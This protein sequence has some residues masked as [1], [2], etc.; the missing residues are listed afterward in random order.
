M[1][2][3]R[4]SLKQL[5][6]QK[7]EI[8]KDLLAFKRS[9]DTIRNRLSEAQQVTDVP[10]LLNWAGTSAVMGSLELSI[11]SLEKELSDYTKAI[12]LVQN[13]EI[14]NVDDD[15]PKP[16]VLKLVPRNHD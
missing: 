1:S 2:E 4:L 15:L 9:Y 11:S 7:E 12:Y 13:G 3:R 6:R 14:L 8:E 10:S 5:M 16:P